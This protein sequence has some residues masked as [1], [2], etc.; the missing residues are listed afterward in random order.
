MLLSIKQLLERTRGGEQSHSKSQYPLYVQ[1]TC[2][3]FFLIQ[4]ETQAAKPQNTAIAKLGIMSVIS[5][6]E[7]G[8]GIQPIHGLKYV[9]VGL[10]MLTPLI[11]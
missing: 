3:S 6:L 11:S 8:L 1:V 9:Q 5:A 2:S 7:S 10:F 4:I